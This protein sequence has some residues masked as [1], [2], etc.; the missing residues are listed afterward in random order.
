M[1]PIKNNQIQLVRENVDFKLV[2]EENNGRYGVPFIPWVN[3]TARVH[4]KNT[5]KDPVS[6]QIGFPFLDL[7][8]FGDEK[9]VL[10]NLNFKVLSNNIEIKT[11][12]KEGLPYSCIKK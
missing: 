10:E 5:S 8:G 11:E 7:Q 6:L 12:I 9:Y 2:V 1:I 4:L 3:V